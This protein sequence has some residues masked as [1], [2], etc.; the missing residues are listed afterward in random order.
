MGA[1]EETGGLAYD[2][3][4]LAFYDREAETYGGRHDSRESPQLRAFLAELPPNSHILELGCGGGQD[5][6]IMMAAGFQV[7]AVDGSPGLAAIAER[8]LGQPVVVLRFEDLA[9]E[10]NFDGIWANA[11]LTH[12]PLA[13]LSDILR[14]VRRALRPAGLFY[15]SFKAGEGGGR[16]KLGRYFSY[17]SEGELRDAYDSAGPWFD[18]DIQ[19]I[20]SGAYDQAV[21][22]WLYVKT[23]RPI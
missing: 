5:A 12:V 23:S 6:S 2:P 1:A 8:R 18:V 14:R 3:Q 21:Q 15:A 16:D 10:S 19:Q 20:T 7:T 13:A 4:T 22:S 9:F 17:V 11:S